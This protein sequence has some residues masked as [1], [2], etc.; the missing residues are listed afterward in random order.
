[1]LPAVSD[2]ITIQPVAA[3][4]EQVN[5]SDVLLAF[6]AFNNTTVPLT[7]RHD[8]IIDRKQNISFLTLLLDD[9]TLQGFTEGS[10][11]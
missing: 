6:R 11:L 9:I 2:Y 7:S 5:P 4:T 3:F 10:D 8:S 1:M